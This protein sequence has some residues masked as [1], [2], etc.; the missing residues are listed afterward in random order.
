MPIA[1][2]SGR[3]EPEAARERGQHAPATTSS[4]T[5]RSRIRRSRQL[6]SI[7]ST[8][9]GIAPART[10]FDSPSA[11]VSMKYSSAAYSAAS[12]SSTA[13][14]TAGTTSASTSAYSAARGERWLTTAVS[15]MCCM[16]CS[17]TTE[18]SMASHRNRIEASSS[19]HTKG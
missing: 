18:P 19:L 16:R 6:A 3:G 14:N 11:G 2:S 12:G 1:L 7:S 15:R 13:R 10:M 5:T 9:T 4:G 17:A 8:P